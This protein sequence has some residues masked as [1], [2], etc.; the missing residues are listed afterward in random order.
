M[1]VCMY[2]CMYVSI[3]LCIY[4]SISKYGFIYLYIFIYKMKYICAGQ[5]EP[6]GG[7]RAAHVPD[8]HFGVNAGRRALARLH[9]RS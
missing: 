1:Y 8:R 4:L 6:R 7:G 9:C 5:Y 2:V 3:Y